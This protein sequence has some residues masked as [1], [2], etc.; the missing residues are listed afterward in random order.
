MS[1]GETLVEA[2]DARCRACASD[3]STEDGNDVHVIWVRADDG[4]DVGDRIGYSHSDKP[5]ACGLYGEHKL[6]R[7][8]DGISPKPR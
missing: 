8:L 4:L 5:G 7:R 1:D 6:V 3:A 2:F